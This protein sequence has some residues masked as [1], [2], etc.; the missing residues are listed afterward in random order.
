M[1]SLAASPRSRKMGPFIEPL[2]RGDEGRNNNS[3]HGKS[4]SN[5][6]YRN[7][8]DATKTRIKKKSRKKGKKKETVATATILESE[9][10]DASVMESE[11]ETSST[12]NVIT[13]T[14]DPF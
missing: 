9:A 3:E 5:T 11:T 8:T 12:D 2:I 1:S 10:N 13:V 7:D 4:G 14:A 6:S